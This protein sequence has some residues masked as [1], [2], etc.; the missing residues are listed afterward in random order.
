VLPTGKEKVVK[1]LMEG[2]TQIYDAVNR[3]QS[4][5]IN[6]YRKIGVGILAFNNWGV[7]RNTG[8]EDNDWYNGHY[9]ELDI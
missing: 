6:T 9:R 5:E 7:Y 8:I 4:I 1:I 2:E 3:D